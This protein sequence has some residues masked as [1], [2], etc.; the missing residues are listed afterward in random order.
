MTRDLEQPPSTLP[1]EESPGP[2]PIAIG[3]ELSNLRGHIG[4]LV[5]PGF[6]ANLG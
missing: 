5:A 6:G 4:R 1:G 3:T 2:I